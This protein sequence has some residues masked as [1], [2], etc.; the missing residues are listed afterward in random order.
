MVNYILLSVDI[1]SIISII[2]GSSVV[3]ASVKAIFSVIQTHM[4]KMKAEITGDKKIDIKKGENSD[5]NMTVTIGEKEVSI[6][7]YNKQE[8]DELLKILSSS[9]T[10]ENDNKNNDKEKL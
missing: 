2:A 10:G 1:V 9:S 6:K 7:N 8:L 5:I 3:A 4:S